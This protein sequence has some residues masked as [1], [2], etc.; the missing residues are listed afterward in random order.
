MSK[1]EIKIKEK[2]RER[3]K[4]TKN[5][6]SVDTMFDRNL[7]F[8]SRSEGERGKG[9]FDDRGRTTDGKIRE[10]AKG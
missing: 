10:R 2:E 5:A 8:V 4:E 3:E 7:H 6:N 1:T 9:E